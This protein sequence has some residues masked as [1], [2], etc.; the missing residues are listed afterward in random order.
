MSDP[1]RRTGL[2]EKET[3][4][5]VPGKADLRR[6][7]VGDRALEPVRQAE[8]FFPRLGGERRRAEAVAVIKAEEAGGVLRK[9]GT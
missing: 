4:T 9:V 6:P 8:R 2:T 1:F 5:G 7:G 3:A